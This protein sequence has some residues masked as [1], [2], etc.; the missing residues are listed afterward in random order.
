M[1]TDERTGH[2]WVKR[3]EGVGRPESLFMLAFAALCAPLGLS[4]IGRFLQHGVRASAKLSAVQGSP[5]AA[6][7]PFQLIVL[8]IPLSL[9]VFAIIF[10]I[11][12]LLFK[13]TLDRRLGQIQFLLA[14]LP[15]LLVP[16]FDIA[17]MSLIPSQRND[18]ITVSRSLL[19]KIPELWIVAYAWSA[20]IVIFLLNV[21]RSSRDAKSRL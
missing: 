12:P 1:W 14:T 15:V 9:P 4:V 11:W 16:L 19:Q 10:W 3:L 2:L 6:L 13:F 20:S 21:F 17:K 8:A 18:H 7:R 5:G